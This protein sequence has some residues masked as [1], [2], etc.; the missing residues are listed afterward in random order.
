MSKLPLFKKGYSGGIKF[1]RSD[2]ETPSFVFFIYLIFIALF[3]SFIFLR[4]FQLTVVKGEYYRNLAEQNRIR[5]I[6]IEAKRG[7]LVDRKGLVIARNLPA[8]IEKIDDRL[9][10]KRVYEEA[11]AIA[12]LIGYRQTADKD[13]LK[14]DLCLNKLKLGDKVGKKGVEKIFDCQLRGKPGKKLIE[15]DARG[16]F[17]RTLTVLPPTD[18]ETIQLSLD[19]LL[20]KKAY[21]LLNQTGESK[22][23]AI[24]ALKPTTGEILAL[25]SNPSFSPQDFEDENLN[26][27]QKYLTDEERPLFN[28]ATEGVYP[29]GSVFKLVVAA[30]ALEEKAIDEKTQFEDT[31]VLQAGPLKFGNWYFLQYGKTEGMVDVV[32][33]IRRSN[34]IFFYLTGSKTGVEKIKVWA[35]KFGYGKKTGFGLDEA[36]GLIPS[37]F[38]KKEVLA[39]SWYL[40]DTYNFSIG[41]GYVSATPLQVAVSTAVFANGGYLC[42]PQIEKIRNSKFEIRNCKKLPISSKTLNLIREGMSQACSPGGTG[43]PLFDFGIRQSSLKLVKNSKNEFQP[44]STSFNQFQRI[45]TACKTGTAESSSK[46]HP[47]HAWITVFAP[48]ENPE[49]VVTVLVENGGQGADVAGP[50][51]KEILKA[52]FERKE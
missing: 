10:S 43:W 25:V 50:I 1:N 13:D 5:E 26:A 32:K 18:G 19:L 30:A 9:R 38:W 49:I 34:D 4:L 41:Q 36:E 6:L 15:V 3:F 28:R 42:Q 45:Q 20:Q 12:H 16:K 27:I 33:A 21:E 7:K 47:P 51:A 39:E 17:L 22:K 8:E 37:P 31:G 11:E 52:Y 40:G 29:P 23:G 35:D 24:I 46:D 48:F 44:V 2:G 14:N